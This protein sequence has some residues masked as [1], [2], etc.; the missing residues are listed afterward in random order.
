MPP[1]VAAQASHLPAISTLFAAFLGYNPVQH[2]IGAGTLAHLGRG[3]AGRAGPAQLLPRA[4]R[5]AVP[6]R[7]ACGVRLRHRHEPRRRSGVVDAR[8]ALRAHACGSRA[9]ARSRPHPGR[10]S[11][12][13]SLVSA[14]PLRRAVGGPLRI[15]SLVKQVPLA[16]SLRLDGGR[17]VRQGVGFEM[18][19]YCR[20]AVSEGV[21]LARATGGSCTVVTLGPLSAEDVLREAVAWGAEEGLHICDPRCAGSDTLATARALAAALRTAGPFDLV[22]L[23][24]NSIDGETGQVGPEVAQLLDLPFASGVRRLEDRGSGLR[25]GLEHDDGSQEVDIELPAVLSVAERLCDPCKVDPAG[26]AAVA[27]ER[28][29]RIT[30]SGLGP[31][32]WGEEGSPTVVGETR[33]MEH[34][35]S[36]LVLHGPVAEQVEE[37]VREL[38]RRGALS[39]GPHGAGPHGTAPGP[40]GARP[41]GPPLEP[42]G[43]RARRARPARGGGRAARRGGAPRPGRRGGRA[44][45]VPG[46]ALSPPERRT[47][48]SS[49]RDHAWRR[50][51]RTP[52]SPTCARPLPGRCSRRAPPSAARSRAAPR[53]RRDRDWWATP[54]PC[55]CATGSW[56]RRSPRSRAPWWPTSRAA[57]RCRW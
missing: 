27:P 14:S 16:E 23:G 6:G 32:P 53:R 21:T 28:I 52:S 39:A 30:A 25:L 38:G 51:S 11:L 50:T 1:A 43:R 20:R 22:L 44:R 26:R 56:W 31:G 19:A 34:E 24:L 18:N 47:S 42:G 57:A 45:T 17:L 10:P 40:P 54:W 36:T 3:A 33:P 35:R 7:S 49:W 46:R 37:A 8:R 5:T 4:H 48:S 12:V 13:S 2:L 15:A 55:R 9:A 29:T 41:A